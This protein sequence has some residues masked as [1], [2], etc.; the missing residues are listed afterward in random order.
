MRSKPALWSDIPIYGLIAPVIVVFILQVSLIWFYNSFNLT[1]PSI[2]VFH[3]L[4]KGAG[5]AD[6]NF[7][8]MP[9][10]IPGSGEINGFLYPVLA[11]ILC[12]ITG[13]YNLIPVIYVLA[14]FAFAFTAALFYKTAAGF[15]KK[16]LA[17]AA[18]AVFITTAPVS[19]AMFSGGDVMLTCLL[20]ALNAY[21]VF[22]SVPEKRYRGAWITAALM[23][24]VSLTGLMFG[25]A[26]AVYIVLKANE[27][28]VRRAYNRNIFMIFA[29]LAVIFSAASA[30]IFIGNLSA[31]FFEQNGMTDV[32]TFQV[33]TFFKDGFLWSKALP[34]FFAVFF[35]IAFF[36]KTAEEIRSKKAGFMIYAAMLTLAA[37]VM[38]FFSAFQPSTDTILFISPFYFIAALVGTAG[39]VDFAVFI[40]RKKAGVFGSE[41]IIYGILIFVIAANV[42]FLFNRSVE[43]DNNIRYMS[44]NT[45]VEKFIER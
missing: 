23:S 37:F 16:E 6:S 29:V 17:L 26:S 22:F 8:A 39:L 30:Y 28:S 33:D 21:F 14:F 42:I 1:F 5:L 45:Y 11:G 4:A 40:Q 38:E 35:Y 32:K 36:M 19:L 9:K 44:G 25:A 15:I 2:Q 10:D 18:S 43:R 24:L 20:L 12:K 3:S 34:P 31:G 7:T 41:N 13:K 27:K